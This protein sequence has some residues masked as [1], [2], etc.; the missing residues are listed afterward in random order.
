[1]TY[2]H[3]AAGLKEALQNDKSAFDADRLQKYTGTIVILGILS[4]KIRLCL[5]FEIYVIKISSFCKAKLVRSIFCSFW[6]LSC[7]LYIFYFIILCYIHIH[8]ASSYFWDKF[9]I[10]VVV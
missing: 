8:V 2:D 5:I 3:L 6:I 1:M 4:F 7:Q 10:I 9:N